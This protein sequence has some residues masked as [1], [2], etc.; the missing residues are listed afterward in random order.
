MDHCSLLILQQLQLCTSLGFLQ[1]KPENLAQTKFEN[2]GL[3]HHIAPDFDVCFLTLT[4]GFL[5]GTV[6]VACKEHD[7]TRLQNRNTQTLHVHPLNLI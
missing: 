5:T 2:Q 7:L 3:Q 4:L 6:F 1:P